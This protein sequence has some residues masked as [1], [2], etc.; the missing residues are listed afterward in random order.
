[1]P[2]RDRSSFFRSL[3]QRHRVSVS[4]RAKDAAYEALQL[5][6][7]YTRTTP[8]E[9][10]VLYPSSWYLQTKIV[11]N[12]VDPVELFTISTLPVPSG[13]DFA[14]KPNLTNLPPQ[15]ALLW[16]T[17]SL[18][19]PG[20]TF[21]NGSSLSNGLRFTDLRGSGEF[22]GTGG[23]SAYSAA[24]TDQI[25]DWLAYLWVGPQSSPDLN[26]FAAI[27]DAVSPRPSSAREPT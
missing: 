1:M 16:V 18:I 4:P 17:A 9:V 7:H 15:S 20:I 14:G 8:P 6:A 25:W 24:Y 3:V 5:D 19:V 23:F 12:L 11:T 22:D 27:M 13:I 21:P 10:T 26:T 2:V